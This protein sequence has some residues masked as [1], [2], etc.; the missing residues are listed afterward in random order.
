MAESHGTHDENAVL[1][2]LAVN[3]YFIWGDEQA[4]TIGFFVQ[5]PLL[6]GMNMFLAGGDLGTL[7]A[8]QPGIEAWAKTQGVSRMVG[9][10][11]IGWRRVFHDYQDAGIMMFKDI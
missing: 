9:G 7:L 4:A 6:K 1:C 3:E 10:G 11:R 5:Y 8:M 2:K